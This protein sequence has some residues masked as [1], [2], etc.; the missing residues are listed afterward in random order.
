MDTLKLGKEMSSFWFNTK[1]KVQIKI[2]YCTRGLYWKR[3]I[4]LLSCRST[5]MW[6]DKK[7]LINTLHISVLT[8]GNFSEFHICDRLG[9][10]STVFPHPDFSL[11]LVLWVMSDISRFSSQE[12]KGRERWY[13]PVCR[14]VSRLLL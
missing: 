6:T 8:V 4:A 2:L 3:R 13:C 12:K 9:A 7:V 1:D 11:Y 14:H 10:L 5:F